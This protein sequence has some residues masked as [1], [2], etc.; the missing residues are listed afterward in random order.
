MNKLNQTMVLV[1]C[2]IAAVAIAPPAVAAAEPGLYIGLSG[3]KSSFGLEQSDLDLDTRSA[4]ISQNV[5]VRSGAS[6]FDDSDTAI[7]FVVGYR[8]LRYIAVEASYLDLGSAKY[9]FT[10]TVSR[11]GLITPQS[12]LVNMDTETKGLTVAA[13]GSLPISDVFDLHARLGLL[14]AQTEVSANVVI[15]S[16]SG[17]DK[18]TSNSVSAL[19]GVG[20]GFHFGRHWSLSVDWARYVNVGDDNSDDYKDG[21]DID[22]LTAAAS[23]RF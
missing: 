2:A 19:F 21:F 18:E 20:A 5:S 9:Q 3:G 12:T 15:G 10:G 13:V 17:L 14:A 7:A 8:F 6:T 22:A 16:S 1:T 11:G 4:F 23:Y